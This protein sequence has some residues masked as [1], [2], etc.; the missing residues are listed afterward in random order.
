MATETKS[1]SPKS[2]FKAFARLYQNET[3]ERR[4]ITESQACFWA[5]GNTA[6][7][8]LAVI[9][10]SD[11]FK[12]NFKLLGPLSEP[13]PALSQERQEADPKLVSDQ[14]FNDLQSYVYEG[15]AVVFFVEA[16]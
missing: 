3:D 2:W 14:L 1:Q 16:I 6:E 10:A 4:D 13:V 15:S 11:A 8:A 9:K 7:E 12:D 5:L